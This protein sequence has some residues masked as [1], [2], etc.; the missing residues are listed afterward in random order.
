MKLFG[1]MRDK[2]TGE[3]KR[4]HNKEL[5]DMQELY[6]MHCSPNIMWVIK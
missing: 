3:W 2:V 6:D 4:I 5:Y 1:P